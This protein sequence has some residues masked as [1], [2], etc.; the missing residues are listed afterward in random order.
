MN[1]RRDK[2]SAIKIKSP[3]NNIH[4]KFVVVKGEN[5]KTVDLTDLR[6]RIKRLKLASHIEIRKIGGQT[7]EDFELLKSHIGLLYDTP[8]YKILFEEVKKVFGDLKEANLKPNTVGAY[9]AGCILTNPERGCTTICN[10][11][12]PRPRTENGWE[13]CNYPVIW[14]TFESGKYK[15]T[16]MNNKKGEKECVIYMEAPQTFG[17]S[18]EE[19][20]YLKGLGIVNVQLIHAPLDGREYKEIS[21]DF[22]DL[23][24]LPVRQPTPVP[25]PI[26]EIKKSQKSPISE[27]TVQNPV[28]AKPQSPIQAQIQANAQIPPVQQPP[29]Q[30]PPVQQPTQNLPVSQNTQVQIQSKSTKNNNSFYLMLFVIILLIGL[31]FFLSRQ[32]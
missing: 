18:Q 23:D 6:N 22:I 25:T 24:K 7:K 30:Q 15:F 32:K 17:F 11:A 29:V 27:K 21:K 8:E 26:P 12:M 2:R 13:F 31:F 5:K 10:G 19:K 28:Q 4:E 9:C 14:A 1:C 16:N 3:I 20:N